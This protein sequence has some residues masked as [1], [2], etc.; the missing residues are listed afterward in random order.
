MP[1]RSHPTNGVNQ[2]G[3]R[4]LSLITCF[5]CIEVAQNFAYCFPWP[6][7]SECRKNC[8]DLMNRRRDIQRKPRKSSEV[9]PVD[10]T[11]AGGLYPRTLTSDYIHNL[12]SMSP[13]STQISF[14]FGH[15]IAKGSIWRQITKYECYWET[16]TLNRLLTSDIT[17]NKEH[18]PSSLFLSM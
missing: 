8:N 11:W 6:E 4:V 12:T 13:K 9:T 5:H 1:V 10:G 18:N 14:S 15:C 3:Q 17:A 7:S 16:K 2:S